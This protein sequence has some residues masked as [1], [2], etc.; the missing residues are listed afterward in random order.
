MTNKRNLKKYRYA[1][2]I[3]GGCN[4]NKYFK[5]SD[6]N[7]FCTICN[8]TWVYHLDDSEYI[9][10]LL[11]TLNWKHRLKMVFARKFNRSKQVCLKYHHAFKHLAY[12]D[13]YCQ[14]Q[15]HN[16]GICMLCDKKTPT[17]YQYLLV[18]K[19]KIRHKIYIKKLIKKYSGSKYK[20]I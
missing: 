9:Q 20:K 8:R 12:P 2:S 7:S 17:F 1:Q 15:W 13:F 5:H 14:R 10:K 3:C 16:K 6:T 19:A 4:T 18:I 11:K